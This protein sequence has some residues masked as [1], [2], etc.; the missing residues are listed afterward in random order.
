M[1]G[2]KGLD[3]LA[4]GHSKQLSTESHAQ[5]VTLRQSDAHQIRCGYC[6]GDRRKEMAVDIRGSRFN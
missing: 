1:L 2:P 3:F 4:E 5:C 6:T